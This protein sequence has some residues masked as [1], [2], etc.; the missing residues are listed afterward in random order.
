MSKQRIMLL[1]LCAALLTVCFSWT[2]AAAALKETL[3]RQTVTDDYTLHYQEETEAASPSQGVVSTQ[4]SDRIGKDTVV[5]LELTEGKGRENYRLFQQ[6]LARADGVHTLTV[7]IARS[8]AYEIDP[9]EDIALHLHSNTILDL[10]GATLLRGEVLTNIFQVCDLNERQSSPGYEL[11]ENIVLRNGTLDG[12]LGNEMQ[13]NLVNIGHSANITFSQVSFLNCRGGHLLELSGCRDCLVENCTFSGYTSVVEDEVGEAIQLD[14]CSASNGT[15]WNGIYCFDEACDGTPCRN[16]TITGCTFLDYPSGVGNHHTLTGGHSSHI[17]IKNNRFLNS[18]AASAPAIWAYGFDN[19]VIADNVISGNYL[20]GIRVSAGSVAISGNTVGSE[21]ASAGYPALYLTL[22]NS[23]VPDQGEEREKEYI[24]DSSVTGNQVFTKTAYG[25]VQLQG[26]SQLSS[27]REN[28]LNNAGGTALLVAG[29]SKVNTVSGNKLTAKTDGIAVDGNGAITTLTGNDLSAGRDGV[30][31][32]GGGKI[33]ALTGGSITAGQNGLSV[34]E[35]GT[36]GTVDKPA[37]QAGSAGVIVKN[38]SIQML[39]NGSVQGASRAVR[40][41][42]G[43]AINAIQKSKLSSDGDGVSISGKNSQTQTIS[44]CQ[45]TA[46]QCGISLQSG[47][48][49]GIVKGSSWKVSAGPGFSAGKNCTVNTLQGNTITSGKSAVLGGSSCTIQY[50]KDN[51]LTSSEGEGIAV[52]GGAAITVISGNT[53]SA[54]KGS[55]IAVQNG[56]VRKISGNTIVKSGKHGISLSKGAK[57]EKGISANKLS[58]CKGSG[59]MLSGASTRAAE[60]SSNTIKNGQKTGITISGAS[61]SGEVRGNTI[62]KCGSHGIYIN[63][64][65]KAAKVRKNKVSSCKGYGIYV[66][67]RSLSAK[68]SANQCKS[69]K[70]GGVRVLLPVSLSE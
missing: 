43:A 27:I 15:L 68:V 52:S 51:K 18:G 3:D 6:A 42:S 17:V 59:I 67:N 36:V 39:S 24:R 69:N 60:I 34:T 31:V 41:E 45:L 37:I 21:K 64:S 70:K 66:K 32:S 58:G 55:G 50:L 16:I 5:E 61:V 4:S 63:E 22:A 9:E 7:T 35:Q 48:S 13:S 2:Q 19:S 46:K 56:R 33:T 49:L 11:A 40:A 38:A 53:V 25:A 62:Q 14:I 23:F 44:S 29:K 12:K 26:G 57:A 47:G 20:N 8:G 54:K 28:R 10:N 1:A 30:C 65:G